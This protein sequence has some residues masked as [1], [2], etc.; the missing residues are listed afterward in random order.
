[1]EDRK[2]LSHELHHQIIKKFKRRKIIVH[3]IDSI[4]SADLVMMPPERG[5]KYILTVI[6]IFSKYSWCIPLKSKTGTE[7]TESF[8]KIF[9]DSGRICKKLWVDKG[10]EF[11]N[12]LLKKLLDQ[13]NIELYSTESELKACVIERYNRTLKDMMYRKFTELDTTK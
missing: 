8:E 12:K 1:M 13:H 10:K 11:H 7:I 6:D 3:S 4:W 9:K 2:Q 5:Y